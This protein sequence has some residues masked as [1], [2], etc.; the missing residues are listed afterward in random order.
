[1]VTLD[2]PVICQRLSER[3]RKGNMDGKRRISGSSL[4]LSSSATKH[5]EKCRV[6]EI[7]E[8]KST[9]EGSQK[10]SSDT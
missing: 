7:G 1:M 8:D 6:R 10:G 4:L 3:E 2:E 9:P 5:D